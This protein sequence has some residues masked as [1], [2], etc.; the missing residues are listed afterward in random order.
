MEGGEDM[1]WCEGFGEDGRVLL[2]GEEGWMVVCW[3]WGRDGGREQAWRGDNS[4]VEMM[5]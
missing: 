1:S 5:G 4:G 2:K 3:G